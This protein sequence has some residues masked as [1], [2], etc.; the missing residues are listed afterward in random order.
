MKELRIYIT[1]N[2]DFLFHFI[3]KLFILNNLYIQS[4]DRN[5]I[6]YEQSII[7]S[8]G[9][10]R[11]PYFTCLFGYFLYYLLG[12]FYLEVFIPYVLLAGMED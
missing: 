4:L 12:V 11:Q 1:P 6:I 2:S 3:T 8:L 10:D 9:K 5:N 7:K